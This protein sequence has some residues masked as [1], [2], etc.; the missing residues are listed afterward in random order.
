MSLERP[1][2]DEMAEYYAPYVDLVPEGDIRDILETQRRETLSFLAAVPE[3]AAHHRYAADKWSV[4]E[5]LSHVNDCERLY[6]M[7]AF[8][9][10]RGMDTSMPSFHSDFAVRT[11]KP[12]DR[13]WTSHVEEFAAIRAA[14]LALFRHL[15]P[16]A[17]PRRGTASNYTFSVRALAYIAAGHVFHHVAVLRERYL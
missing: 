8:W 16:E 7:R 11:A 14:T 17:W 13:A 12:E 1:S 3:T 5:V 9:F 4:C 10:A 2:L 15:P 6:T